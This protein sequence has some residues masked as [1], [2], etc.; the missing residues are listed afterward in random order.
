MHSLC[1]LVKWQAELS[2]QTSEAVDRLGSRVAT[3]RGSIHQNTTIRTVW[4]ERKRQQKKPSHTLCLFRD[5]VS[6]PEFNEAFSRFCSWNQSNPPGKNHSKPSILNH[7]T[8]T[9][10]RISF[11]P[12]KI[13]QHKGLPLLLVSLSTRP[14]YRLN[15]FSVITTTNTQVSMAPIAPTAMWLYNSTV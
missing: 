1:L 12:L 5:S 7:R 8:P 15:W 6:G 2:S 11:A 14:L 4:G 13:I 9:L 10:L 3:K